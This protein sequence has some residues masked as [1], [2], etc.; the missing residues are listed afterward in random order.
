VGYYSLYP[1][2]RYALFLPFEK[3]GGWYIG[4]GGGYMT[5]EFAY[6][7]GNVSKNAFAACFTTGFNIGNMFDISY[8]LRTDFKMAD[9]KISAGYTYRFK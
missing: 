5:A 3:K 8:T 9:N 7:E 2:A 4:A 1:Y 6:P